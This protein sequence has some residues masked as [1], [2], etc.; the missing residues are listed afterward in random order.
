MT[1]AVDDNKNLVSIGRYKG[2]YFARYGE[3]LIIENVFT[4]IG[5]WIYINLYNS[6][7][8]NPSDVTEVRAQLRIPNAI[9]M[10]FL[11]QKVSY[12][13]LI[14]INYSL[15]RSVNSAY[16]ELSYEHSGNATNI[17]LYTH[18]KLTRFSDSG[19]CHWYYCNYMNWIVTRIE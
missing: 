4:D 19:D 6:F 12:T 8:S 2:K 3:T 11:I 15:V 16:R 5:D 14:Q 7:P 10:N 18:F 17:P 9:S 1:Y 13:N